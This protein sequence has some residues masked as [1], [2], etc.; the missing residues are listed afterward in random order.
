MKI[1]ISIGIWTGSI[2]LTI[3][4]FLVVF[5]LNILLFP[6]D[7]KKKVTHAQDRKSVV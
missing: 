1:I 7:K 6:F 2:L 4:L 3:L 5:A